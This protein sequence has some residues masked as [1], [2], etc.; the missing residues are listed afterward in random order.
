M[1]S[2]GDA[3]F[4]SAASESG[5]ST[6]V[7]VLR[8]QITQLSRQLKVAL[9][10]NRP[11]PYG[12]PEAPG[13]TFKRKVNPFEKAL[14]VRE[15]K[16][17]RSLMRH[18]ITPNGRLLRRWDVARLLSQILTATVMP[19]EVAFVDGFNLPLFV[20]NRMVDLIFFTS[21]VMTFFTPFRE[22]QEKGG[23]GLRKGR[24]RK[25]HTG[26]GSGFPQG[27]LTPKGN[28]GKKRSFFSIA[29]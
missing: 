20:T 2:E 28:K 23:G 15:T 5:G 24:R 11:F 26:K 21:M 13:S 17:L 18:L 27:R 16:R 29:F 3:S 4:C 25:I 9:D 22:S 19:V 12:S 1:H 14:M 10:D 6:E 8:K 7:A